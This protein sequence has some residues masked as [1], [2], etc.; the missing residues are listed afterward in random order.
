MNPFKCAFSSS[1][2]KFLG[3]TLHGKGI[4]LDSAKANAIQDMEPPKD[5]QIVEKFNE[6]SSQVSRF[7]LALPE[8]LDCP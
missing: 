4:N 5:T 7:I 3:F 2:G 1:L 6:E 8:L